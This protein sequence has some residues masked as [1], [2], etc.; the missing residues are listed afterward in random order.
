MGKST[1]T[2]SE[3]VTVA[4]KPREGRMHLFDTADEAIQWLREDEY[5]ALDVLKANGDVPP[6]LEPPC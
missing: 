2:T 6:D 1:I 5:E 3:N 4:D